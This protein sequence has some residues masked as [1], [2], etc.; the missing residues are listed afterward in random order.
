MIKVLIF[1]A[2]G[3]GGPGRVYC[4]YCMSWEGK[5]RAD[6]DIELHRGWLVGSVGWIL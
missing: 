2:A 6:I 5:G 3:V 4:M 1:L